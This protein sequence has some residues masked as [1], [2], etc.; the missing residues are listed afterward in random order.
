[1]YE[2]RSRLKSHQQGELLK[3]FV[4][5]ATAWAATEV[6][7][8]HR[9]TAAVFFM[10][11]RKLIASKLPSYELSG[12]VEADESYFGGIRVRENE[13]VVQQAKWLYLAY[14]SG[15]ARYIYRYRPKLKDS[16]IASHHRRK[17]YPG[18]YR[19][20]RHIQILQCSWYKWFSSQ[21]NQP[22]KTVRRLTKSH[23]WN[24]ELLEPGK[25]SIAQI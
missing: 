7:G 13:D 9:N 2:R 20:H 17:S 1:M 8:V 25:A 12:E 5:G 10:P 19:L 15:V 24:R 22:L 16:Y 6:I 23:Q 21:K 3:M 18:Q 11:L 4:V 14:W